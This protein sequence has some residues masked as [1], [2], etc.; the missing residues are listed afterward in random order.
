MAEPLN[1]RSR[2]TRAAVL[3]A[4]RRVVEDDGFE[5]LTMSRVAEAAGVSRQAVYLHAASRTDLVTQLFRHVNEHEDLERSVRSVWAAPDAATGLEEWA[6]HLARFQPRV[7]AILRA[8]DQVRR[9]DPD[10]DALWRLVMRDW[11]RGCHRL[12]AW[13]D[14]DGVLAEP[15]DRT[16]AAEMLWALMSYD[17]ADRLTTDRRWSRRRLGDHLAVLLA[18]TFL[19]AGG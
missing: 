11:M 13:L 14:D 15:W 18:R 8:N 1:E 9:T 7:A 3:D 12:A 10:A 17:V 4:A 19:R 2:R 6:H 16:S 5:A